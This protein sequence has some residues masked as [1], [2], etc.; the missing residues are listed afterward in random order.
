MLKHDET[1][2]VIADSSGVSDSVAKVEDFFVSKGKISGY[3]TT[4][5]VVEVDGLRIV[6]FQPTIRL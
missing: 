5:P 4:V 6:E 2:V 3:P 1:E